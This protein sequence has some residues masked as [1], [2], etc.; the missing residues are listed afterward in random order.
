[1][2]GS[3]SIFTSFLLP[4]SSAPYPH[5]MLL[6]EPI[7][8]TCK[9]L[10]QVRL[11]QNNLKAPAQASRSP[12]QPHLSS[13]IHSACDETSPRP[14]QTNRKGNSTLNPFVFVCLCDRTPATISVI[15]LR[16]ELLVPQR[17]IRDTCTSSSNPF[18][19]LGSW[20]KDFE[21]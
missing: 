10:S 15:A 11:Q 12:T 5:V 13:P 16:P 3:I 18:C 19:E 6:S 20:L 9:P 14:Q 21:G 8:A 4:P 7:S 2:N 1:M 17:R